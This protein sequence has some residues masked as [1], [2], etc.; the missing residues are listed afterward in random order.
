M[1]DKL[2]K[3]M[4]GR[5]GIDALSRFIFALALILLVISRFYLRD[6]FYII[7]LMTI[8][9]GYYRIFSRNKDRRY[10]E[11]N[12]YLAY[13]NKLKKLLHKQKYMFKQRKVYRIYSCPNC[14]QKIRVPKGKGKIMITCP[15]CR[16]EFIKRS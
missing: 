11:N 1:K 4:M 13:M 16:N 2:R 15:K 5:Y 10:R 3:F 12:L 6:F 9:Y 7:S 14:K 8:L